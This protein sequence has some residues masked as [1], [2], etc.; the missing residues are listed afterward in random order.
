[1]NDGLKTSPE[2]P[3]QRF[4]EPQ[5]S[6][7]L[8]SVSYMDKLLTDVEEILTA[9]S[10]HAFPKY[11]NPLTPAQIRTAKDCIKRL[12]QQITHVLKDLEIALPEA[13]FDST[14]AIRVTLQFIEVAIEE[15][16]PE[17]LVGYGRVP[18]NFAY[19]LAGFRR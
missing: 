18:E 1:M 14:H 10:S 8:A 12:R 3:A 5:Q 15:I 11:K 16:S 13:K 6:R 19:L 17:R 7:I 9:A 4:S 2:Y